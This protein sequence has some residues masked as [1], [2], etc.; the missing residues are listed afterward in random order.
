[1]PY[2]DITALPARVRNNLPEHAQEIFRNA[3][4]NAYEQ[5]K[6]PKKRKGNASLE[7]IANRVA[8]SAVKKEY[9]KDKKTGVWKR[10]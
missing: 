7:E 6:N 5:Y 8:W 9:T 10:K 3:H 2:D 4:N 1:M